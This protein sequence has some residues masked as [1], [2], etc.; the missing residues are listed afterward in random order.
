MIDVF[1]ILTNVLMV[2]WLSAGAVGLVY[3]SIRL[4]HA[5]LKRTIDF[6]RSLPLWRELY[7][8]KKRNPQCFEDGFV[9]EMIEN[10]R[11]ARLYDGMTGY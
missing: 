9:E 6:K 1:M 5:T 4:S 2:L 3:A 11:K 10:Q 7:G 8:F